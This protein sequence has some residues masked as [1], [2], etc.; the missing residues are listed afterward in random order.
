MSGK[1]KDGSSKGQL[2]DNIDLLFRRNPPEVQNRIVVN[3][4]GEMMRRVQSEQLEE[5]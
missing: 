2:V 1:G 3:C 4:I 5:L